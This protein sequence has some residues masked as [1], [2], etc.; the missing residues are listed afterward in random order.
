MD[1]PW[2]SIF[3]NSMRQPLLYFRYRFDASVMNSLTL[4]IPHVTCHS[5]LR[6]DF[7]IYND[8]AFAHDLWI[9][10]DI[11]FFTIT[12]VSHE[13]ILPI[14]LKCRS[15]IHW[16]CRFQT[17]AVTQYSLTV[18]RSTVTVFA[19][20]LLI[21][22]DIAILTIPCVD[23]DSIFSIDLMHRSWIHLRC[24]FHTSPVTQYSLT[25]LKVYSDSVFTK[26]LWIS[27]DIPFLTLPCISHD[28]IFAID[29]MRRSW[30]QLWMPLISCHSVFRDDFLVYSDSV[31]ADDL[32]ING[33]ITFLTIPCI[34]HDSIFAIDS[35][36]Q[37]AFSFQWWF[38]SVFAD[39]LWIAMT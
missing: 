17:S 10:S 23:H 35:I 39:D 31:F 2:H 33:D 28:F 7:L 38:Q 13:S 6:E 8:S 3:D 25:I 26:D 24:Q 22:N 14:D 16:R 11:T 15:W 19:D 36:R 1:Q 21:C 12:C 34:D 37:L 9:S 29:L 27:Y 18:S 20:D 4:W 32:C 5:V 30:N